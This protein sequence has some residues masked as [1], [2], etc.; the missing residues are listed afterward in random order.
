MSFANGKIAKIWEIR[1]QDKY[2]EVKISTSKKNKD[3]DEYEQDFSAFV[4]F[5]GK[6]HE[7]CQ[8]LKGDE[9][10]KLLEV[11]VTNKYVKDKNKSYYNC[12]CFN[13]D[14]FDNSNKGTSKTKDDGENT[15]PATDNENH[16]P[17]YDDEDKLPF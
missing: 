6:A 14:L 13:F 2:S 1:P 12:V 11:E 10:I 9:M 8:S 15:K 4:R 17:L 5:I 16:P 7:K 3:T